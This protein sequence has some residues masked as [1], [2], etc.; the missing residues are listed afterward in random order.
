MTADDIVRFARECLDTPFL[1]QGRVAGRGLDC[2]GVLAHVMTRT[3]LPYEDMTGYPRTPYAR[4]I[5]QVMDAQPS[6]L[7]VRID[8]FR[9]GDF[10]LMRFSD[11]PQHLAVCAGDTI[12][13]AYQHVGKCCEHRLA[14]VW[15]ARIVRAYRVR[16]LA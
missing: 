12:I 15:R 1:H 9:A 4:M 11:E 5:E 3:G 10:L 2:A 16:G 6:M 8:E 7:P 13:H 14:S